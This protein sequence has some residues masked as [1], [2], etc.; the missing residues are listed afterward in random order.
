[1]GQKSGFDKGKV[2]VLFDR[3]ASIEKACRLILLPAYPR[4]LSLQPDVFQLVVNE[5]PAVTVTS[6]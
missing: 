2:P 1:M 4:R 6:R 5:T 3:E